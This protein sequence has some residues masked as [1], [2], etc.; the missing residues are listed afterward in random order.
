[1][2]GLIEWRNLNVKTDEP[3]M[4]TVSIGDQ[5]LIL[6]RPGKQQVTFQVSTALNGAGERQDSGCTP[7]G[8]HRISEKIGL[9]APVGSVFVGREPTG[10]VLDT[11][12]QSKHPERD[13]I[14]SRILWLEGLEPGVNSG[15][16][17]DSKARYIYIHGTPDTEPMGVPASH[18]CIRMTNDDVIELFESVEE[19]QLVLIR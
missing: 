10:E 15:L 19:G 1:M 7:R 18:G 13:W 3:V 14:L 8:L 12:L 4:I 16:G 2:Y 6:D 17:C 9:G 11:D 5:K